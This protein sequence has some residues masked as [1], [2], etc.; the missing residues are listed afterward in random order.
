MFTKF[1]STKPDLPAISAPRPLHRKTPSPMVPNSVPFAFAAT[2]ALSPGISQAECV[3][4]RPRTRRAVATLGLS[5]HSDTRRRVF[6]IAAGPTAAGDGRVWLCWIFC[7]CR[8]TRAPTTST[9]ETLHEVWT[10][11]IFLSGKQ[12]EWYPATKSPPSPIW[13]TSAGTP[14]HFTTREHTLVGGQISFGLQRKVGCV[15]LFFRLK[16]PGFLLFEP[17]TLHPQRIVSVS[18]PMPW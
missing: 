1:T 15:F 14:E 8:E 2:H 17:I 18:L 5:V 12:N 9:A 11:T 3:G 6:S 13:C 4:P 7:P 10:K 16:V